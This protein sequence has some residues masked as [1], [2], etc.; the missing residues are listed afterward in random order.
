M[1]IDYVIDYTCVPKQTLTTEGIVERLKAR[2]RAGAVI[3]L[4]RENGDQRP[5]SE[6]GF[7]FTRTTV[8]GEEE[9]RVI[10]VQVM[11]DLA[12]QLD[13]LEQHCAGCPANVSGRPFGC[14]GAIQYPITAAAERWL[15]DQL[16][17]IEEP[18]TWLLLRQGVQDLGYDGEAVR[19]LRATARVLLVHRS[20]RV[21][22]KKR[23]MTLRPVRSTSARRS[24]SMNIPGGKRV[25][26]SA[27]S[28][29]ST[30]TWN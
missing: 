13:P 7:E 4:F 15:L 8:E 17:D 19:P 1:A 11:L 26:Q 23:L 24:S 29:R 16:P 20:G 21:A 28:D 6:M 22:S 3:K 9:T 30:S 2:E 10:V 14:V 5:P 27:A 18:L 12:A 25:A